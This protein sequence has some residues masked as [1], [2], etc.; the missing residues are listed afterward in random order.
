MK[1][2]NIIKEL[3][4]N[5]PWIMS[6]DI[7]PN[8]SGYSK[9]IGKIKTYCHEE[10][11]PM[12]ISFQ[13][14][15]Q[16]ESDFMERFAEDELEAYVMTVAG[17]L[18]KINIKG[19]ETVG[20]TTSR[21]WNEDFTDREDTYRVIYK[22]GLF[23]DN[24]YA[25]I[26]CPHHKDEIYNSIPEHLISYVAEKAVEALS[27][28]EW[29]WLTSGM[30]GLNRDILDKFRANKEEQRKTY[31]AEFEERQRQERLK[32]P[33]DPYS[34][35]INLEEFINSGGLEAANKEY[36]EPKGLE[37]VID[38]ENRDP[39]I[40]GIWREVGQQEQLDFGED[41]ED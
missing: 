23:C 10:S 21:P 28:Q 18:E 8:L 34:D 15:F 27:D 38:Y 11:C 25:Q 31:L 22:N 35:Y 6:L 32:Y 13:M 14:D 37:L 26:Y 40:R 24:R 16:Q 36:F 12:E 33:E 5:N 9:G 41:F 39:Y 30:I 1:K 29:G 2:E 3:I 7:D 4:Y 19:W 17:L 20:I